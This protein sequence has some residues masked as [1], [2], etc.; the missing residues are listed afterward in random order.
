M[1]RDRITPVRPTER[2][3][4]LRIHQRQCVAVIVTAGIV[5]AGIVAAGIVAAG[6][7]AAGAVAAGV[8]DAA[9]IKTN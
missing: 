7:V 1:N 6:I 4:Y 9:P 8:V 2:D 5:A 3:S